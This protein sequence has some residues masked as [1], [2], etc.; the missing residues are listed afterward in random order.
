MWPRETIPPFTP[1]FVFF[2]H[3]AASKAW[4]WLFLWVP[5]PPKV[6]SRCDSSIQNSLR[7]LAS[8]SWFMSQ[9]L[10]TLTHSYPGFEPWYVAAATSFIGAHFASAPP[11]CSKQNDHLNPSHWGQFEAPQS[12]DRETIGVWSQELWKPNFHLSKHHHQPCSRYF[13][14]SQ[15]LVMVASLVCHGGFQ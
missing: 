10:W 4:L 13:R 1:F 6:L 7:S 8:S 9:T 5:Q 11:N 3:I 14:F 15:S 12:D 2:G